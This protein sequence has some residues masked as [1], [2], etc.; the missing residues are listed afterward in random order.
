MTKENP[1]STEA[2]FGA[3]LWKRK[4]PAAPV[5]TTPAEPEQP[6]VIRRVRMT[7][8]IPPAV[9]QIQ[10]PNPVTVEQV[11]VPMEPTPVAVEEKPVVVEPA[12]VE[13]PTPIVTAPE[14][15][16]QITRESESRFTGEME[17]STGVFKISDDEIELV[18]RVTGLKFDIP[19]HHHQTVEPP[20]TQQ[21]LRDE[22]PEEKVVEITQPGVVT[23]TVEEKP[24][25]TFS[26]PDMLN[27]MLGMLM[28][29]MGKKL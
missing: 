6:V 23:P 24:R 26:N 20:V 22:N 25:S 21:P 5:A 10:T 7:S 3:L 8:E 1:D 29:E 15:I 11:V 27:T 18:E 17:E 14:P 4:Q 28:K 16:H 12:V 9:E 19:E 2:R 13:T